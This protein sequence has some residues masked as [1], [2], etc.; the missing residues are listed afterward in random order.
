MLYNGTGLGMVN[1]GLG[2]ADKAER[3]KRRNGR[4]GGTAE[5]AEWQNGRT[6]EKAEWRNGRTEN[7]SFPSP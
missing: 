7:I 3:Q 1:T 6:A 4:K 2:K 5:K